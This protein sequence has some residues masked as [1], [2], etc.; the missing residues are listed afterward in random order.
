MA[1]KKY[2]LPIEATTL[3]H[4][5]SRACIAPISYLKR[6]HHDIVQSIYPN[7]LL[8]TENHYGVKGSNCYLVVNMREEEIM[9]ERM[10][11][12]ADDFYLYLGALPISRVDEIAFS[13]E[14]QK[15]TTI[16]NVE[17]GNAFVRGCVINADK[18]FDQVEIPRIDKEVEK[19]QELV[20]KLQEY[21]R[22]MGALMFM[23]LANENGLTY[24]E[25]F[26]QTTALYSRYFA[27]QLKEIGLDTVSKY[28]KFFDENLKE[29][30]KIVEGF[31]SE[32]V[33][34]E[35]AHKSN[36]SIKI[37][38]IRGYDFQKLRN[39]NNLYIL[40]LLQ[41]FS[42]ADGEGGRDKIDDL[43]LNGFYHRGFIAPNKA[44]SFAF[45]YGYNRGYNKFRNQYKLDKK[46]KVVKFR[47]DSIFEKYIAEEVFQTVVLDSPINELQFLNMGKTF[48]SKTIG[49][50]EYQILDQT[51]VVKKKT[52]SKI[53]QGSII[54]SQVS[55]NSSNN[56]SENEN[57]RDQY[58][59]VILNQKERREIAKLGGLTKNISNEQ[60]VVDYLRTMS[61]SQIIDIHI[62]YTSNKVTKKES[63]KE[64]VE[65]PKVMKN[66]GPELF[67]TN[68]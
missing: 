53:A 46:C 55:A 6:G 42:L 62:N 16:T 48:E 1:T 38:P 35:Y 50:G 39:N 14:D 67:D 65:E 19:N 4:Y 7:A 11:K 41:N 9:S 58:I 57:R 51:I 31:I 10:C 64:V 26:L 8:L 22:V 28:E 54:C 23:R 49:E 21:D 15:S 30:R 5:Y 25:N 52:E 43:I 32:D 34:R 60:N 66:K 44:E 13:S 47:F 27:T 36:I 24:S 20:E 18:Q 3:A 29:F 33:V 12:I 17:M 59:N 37:D 68:A 61:L 40:A 2:I 56:S 45:Y 63:K